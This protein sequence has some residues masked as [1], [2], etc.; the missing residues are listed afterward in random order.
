MSSVSID[1]EQ[2]RFN[3]RAASDDEPKAAWAGFDIDRWRCPPCRYPDGEGRWVSI[4]A[5][6][7]R[8][9]ANPKSRSTDE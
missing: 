8:L 9:A 2:R 7:A 4:H 5:D 1:I 3:F 6:F